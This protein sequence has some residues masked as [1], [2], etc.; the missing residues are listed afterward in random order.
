TQLTHSTMPTSELATTSTESIKAVC[1]PTPQKNGDEKDNDCDGFI[2]E[3][4]MN[5][6]DDDEDG[7]ID[8]DNSRTTD[9]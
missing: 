5:G 3:E 9:S 1:T 6:K 7:E 4:I 2:D 8:E